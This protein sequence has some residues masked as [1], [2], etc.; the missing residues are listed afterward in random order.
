VLHD[1]IR[2]STADG[3]LDSEE[4]DHLRRGAEAM[5]IPRDVFVELR[6]IVA[7]EGALR[8]RRHQLVVAPVLPGAISSPAAPPADR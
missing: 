4:V 8:Q 3:D 5:E 7:A 1:A 6:A 2:M